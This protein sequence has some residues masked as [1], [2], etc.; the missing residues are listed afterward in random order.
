MLGVRPEAQR[1]QRLMG[2]PRRRGDT[3]DVGRQASWPKHVLQQA[4]E[5]A[6]PAQWV[7][8]IPSLIGQAMSV[9]SMPHPCAAAPIYQPVGHVR[10][11]TLGVGQAMHDSGQCGE[12]VIDLV[13]LR[14]RLSLRLGAIRS[15]RAS[16]ILRGWC[17]SLPHT[18]KQNTLLERVG[19]TL[20][21]PTT[22]PT[23]RHSFPR[24][25]TPPGMDLV[26]L[27]SMMQCDR[28][29]PEFM[30]V[31][32]TARLARAED[33]RRRQWGAEATCSTVASTAVRPSRVSFSCVW[34]ICGVREL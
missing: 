19:T 6:G 1:A 12:G 5:L 33:R 18:R 31:E 7:R 9:S 16:K 17:S 2:V 23:T 29:L 13:A 11:H 4:S 8:G 25:V 15:L 21:I 30:A 26:T 10:G 3:Q 20:R 14:Q 27:R 28:L 32:L 24:V 22:L 34:H